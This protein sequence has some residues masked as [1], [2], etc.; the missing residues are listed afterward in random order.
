MRCAPAQISDLFGALF[1]GLS[2]ASLDAKI[3][4]V[5][6]QFD[7][8]S[9]G[10]LDFDEFTAAC[11]TMG[12]RL[13]ADEL[14][15]L[16]DDFDQD[17]GGD[18]SFDEFRHMVKAKLGRPCGPEC[19]TC[20][21]TDPDNRPHTVF[22]RRWG[23]VHP[24][25][26]TSAAQ[27]LQ[28]CVRRTQMHN[29]NDERTSLIRGGGGDAMTG[30]E[31][32][33]A[34]E[35]DAM[36]NEKEGG[37]GHAEGCF[38]TNAQPLGLQEEQPPPLWW[39]QWR[40]LPP[41]QP[42]HC[43]LAIIK[44]HLSGLLLSPEEEL[45][46]SQASL[47]ERREF[48]E[49]RRQQILRRTVMATPRQIG[50]LNASTTPALAAPLTPR[51]VR[52]ML[53][54]A[55]SDPG[56][57]AEAPQDDGLRQSGARPLREADDCAE[58]SRVIAEEMRNDGEGVRHKISPGWTLPRVQHAHTTSHMLSRAVSDPEL[59]D[60]LQAQRDQR[61]GERV[62]NDALAARLARAM[63]ERGAPATPREPAAHP[64]S[65]RPAAPHRSRRRSPMRKPSAP[66][67]S[68]PRARRLITKT[69][70]L[71]KAARLSPKRRARACPPATP[72]RVRQGRRAAVQRLREEIALLDDAMAMACVDATPGRDDGSLHA[73][74][75]YLHASVE[76]SCTHDVTCVHVCVQSCPT[77]TC[78]YVCDNMR[79]IT[80]RDQRDVEEMVELQR[81]ISHLP[82]KR[83]SAPG[84]GSLATLERGVGGGGT[85]TDE[86]S[87][88]GLVGAAH[89]PMLPEATQTQPTTTTLHVS[90]TEQQR[91]L[92]RLQL[93]AR[94]QD[95]LGMR[96]SAALSTTDLT[97]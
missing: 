70:H 23:A 39:R 16:F 42:S 43:Q 50:M 12:L 31:A 28:A 85:G 45:M 76:P 8:D 89:V 33:A 74:P 9:S 92:L 66:S 37:A 3:L 82:D 60:S 87:S 32:G 10:F 41:K 47:R 1:S 2:G 38:S 19:E 97:P 86:G 68:P 61:R 35:V 78:L 73:R 27:T 63:A 77:S 90:S 57:A 7:T 88:L 93:L 34:Q 15:T 5:F 48:A 71:E 17:G 72:K 36:E 54:R 56:L 69:H 49:T 81:E 26:T 30:Q 75:R 14:Q 29:G 21:I 6:R 67:R 84:E 53:P 4:E 18:I 20:M 91:L 44:R 51:P 94:S 83:M 22:L 64:S 25:A 62:P 65:S 52:N 58:Y 96:V 95:W 13:S 55:H 11:A 40:Q 80:H 79:P 24:V 46:L 59:N